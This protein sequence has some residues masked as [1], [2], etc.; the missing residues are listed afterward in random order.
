MWDVALRIF[1]ATYMMELMGNKLA[2]N[3]GLEYVLKEVDGARK[4]NGCD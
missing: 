1:S 2:N 3:C 4:G